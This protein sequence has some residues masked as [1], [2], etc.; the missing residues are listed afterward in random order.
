M[1]LNSQQIASWV[2]QGAAIAGI[3]VVGLLNVGSLPSGVRVVLTAV[4]GIVLSLEHYVSDPSTGLGSPTP[5][6]PGGTVP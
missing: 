3:V 4:S 6:P 2:R 5:K 1:I